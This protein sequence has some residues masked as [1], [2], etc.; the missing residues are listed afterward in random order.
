LIVL[1]AALPLTVSAQTNPINPKIVEFDP[2]LD[3]AA[4]TADGQ[5]MVARYDLLVFLQGAT[6]PVTTTSLGKPSPDLDGK[7][8]VDF[9]TIL[10]GWP[11]VNGTYQARVA[12]VGPTGTGQSD[13]SNL[14][15][16]QSAV[17]PPPP[18]SCT[19]TVSATGMTAAP[20]GQA[21]SVTVTASAS[22]CTWT[23]ASD[24]GFVEAAPTGGT[25]SGTV[26]LTVAA[27]TGAARTATVTIGGQAYTVSQAAAPPPPPP[28]CTFIVSP[29]STSVAGAAGSYTAA[30]VASGNSCSWG[31]TDTVSW[32]A[33]GTTSGA[34]TASVSYT[35]SKNNSGAARSGTITIGGRTLAVTQASMPR[36]N[37]PKGIK[38][39]SV[40]T[41]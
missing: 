4:L 18:P 29:S 15:D 24:S 19:F 23:A 37:P 39:S 2:S 26:S 36:P 6:Q 16:F 35:L 11:L 22:S 38:L 14:F 40:T 28:S 13:P 25:G 34:G 3:Q 41:K 27:N 1:F 10:V 12:A 30:L 20:S 32:I 7:I 31:A 9:S 8:R 33:L 17:P 21:G 5:P